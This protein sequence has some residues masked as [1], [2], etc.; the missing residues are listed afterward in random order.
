VEMKRASLRFRQQVR[1]A[2]DDVLLCE[3][4]F[5]V[6]CV[7]T[8]NLKPRPIPEALRIAFAESGLPPAGE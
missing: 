8:E 6:A 2:Q 7:R 3:G 4:Q 5:L 1:R